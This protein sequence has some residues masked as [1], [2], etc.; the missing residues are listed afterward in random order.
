MSTALGP[1]SQLAAAFL[2]RFP[3]SARLAERGRSLFPSGVTHDARYLEPYPIYAVRAA[4]SRKWDVDGNELI[5]YWVGHGALLLGHAH[6]AVVEAVQQQVALGTHHGACHELE[7]EWGELVRRLVPSCERLRFTGSGTEAT[8]MAL[9]LARIVS[10]RSKIL[11]FAGHFHG[12]HDFLIPAADPPHGAD[13]VPPP[14]VT[15]GVLDDLIVVPP[16]DIEAVKQALAEHEPACVILEPTGGRWGTVPIRGEFL[17]EL[18]RATAETGT[19]LIF[20]EVVTGFRVHPGGAQGHYGV[21]PD[22]TTLAKVLAGGLPGGCV[23]GRKE[24]LEPLSFDS[25]PERKMKHPGTYNANPLSAAAGI[26]ALKLVADGQPCDRANQAAAELRRRLNQLFHRK[27]VPWAA[28]GDFSA[29]KIHPECDSPPPADAGD[30]FVPFS[31]RFDKLERK[32]DRQ[33]GYA[34]R[35]ALL[36]EGVD[37]MGFGGTTS[38]VHSQDDIDHT[39]DAFDAATDRLREAGVID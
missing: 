3:G 18:R 34:F 4:G 7:L 6:P 16:N 15:R 20:D 38:A 10:G 31:G 39:V 11:K 9:R 5:D 19:I 12:W 8:L 32:F 25:G 14:G 37:W 2:E 21:T 33:L 26:A 27:G 29:I 30:D 23:A 17:Q 28:Y 36:L 24:L 35:C 1:A 22:L 13:A